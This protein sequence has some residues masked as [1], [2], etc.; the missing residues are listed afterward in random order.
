MKKTLSILMTLTIGSSAFAGLGGYT[1]TS[2]S[3]ASGRTVVSAYM[4]D[5]E[6]NMTVI[7]DGKASQYDLGKKGVSFAGNDETLIVKKN[8]SI[9]VALGGKG[10]NRTLTI[11]PGADPRKGT[12]IDY[13]AKTDLQ[14]IPVT[15]KSYTKEP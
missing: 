9:Q 3:S 4:G 5:E 13:V 1:T 7:V 12:D 10:T 11:Q 2:C 15:C 14:S 8:N 6:L